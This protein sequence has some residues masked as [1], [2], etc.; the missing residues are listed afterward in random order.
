MILVSYP[1]LYCLYVSKGIHYTLKLPLCYLS[2]TACM[3]PSHCFTAGFTVVYTL[4]S[5]SRGT[6]VVYALQ[7]PNKGIT[8]LISDYFTSILTFVCLISVLNLSAFLQ[9]STASLELF[10]VYNQ[11]AVDWLQL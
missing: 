7:S 2:T 5:P 6:T 10:Y 9:S 8:T 3:F 11:T 4:Q 1:S